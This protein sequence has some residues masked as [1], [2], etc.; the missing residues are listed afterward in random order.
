MVLRSKNGKL[1][2]LEEFS[3]KNM[4]KWAYS[5]LTKDNQG[6]TSGESSSERDESSMTETDTSIDASFRNCNQPFTTY[7]FLEKYR[8]RTH[9]KDKRRCVRRRMSPSSKILEQPVLVCAHEKV[10]TSEC[11][12]RQEKLLGITLHD[13]LTPGVMPPLPKTESE[14]QC[15]ADCSSTTTLELLTPTRLPVLEHMKVIPNQNRF[16]QAP[17]QPGAIFSFLRL[18]IDEFLSEV[19][20]L[21]AS[22][23]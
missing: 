8:P 22:N 5:S 20:T 9:L 17:F 2:V 15:G 19:Q 13:F 7:H 21:E 10:P 3:G 18:E 4:K 11:D 14:V 12:Y 23:V 6:N 16:V 1:K